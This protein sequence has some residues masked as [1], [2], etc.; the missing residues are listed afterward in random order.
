MHKKIKPEWCILI[1]SI[2]LFV[3]Y[4]GTVHLFDWDEINF[5]E[6]AR[7]MIVTGDYFRV[8]ID[9]RPFWEKPPLFIWMQVLSMKIFGINEFSA[10]FP[11]AIA[12]IATLQILYYL[13][14]KM[15]NHFFGLIW[16]MVYAGTFLT[17][18]YFKT[19]I[20]DP[21][22]NLFIFLSVY[23][24]SFLTN[25]VTQ[26]RIWR[27]VY[28]GLFLGLAVL[29]KGPV[30]ILIVLLSLILFLVLNRFRK[31]VSLKELLVL[32][33][34]SAV[35][36]FFWFGVELLK[37]GPWFLQEFIV[38]QI[39]L[40]QTQDAGHGG[41]FF[42]HW[43]VI[44][45][46]CFP[47]SLFFVKAYLLR[48]TIDNEHRNFYRWMN[49]LFWVVLIL[50]SIVKTK[51]IHYSS[52]CYFPLSFL[53]AYAI[54]FLLKEK[55]K[56]AKW[57]NYSVLIIGVLI[58]TLLIIFPML[59]MNKLSWIEFIKDDF[60]RANLDA[61]INWSIIDSLGG[62][63]LMLGLI[64]F[65][66]YNS[67]LENWKAIRSLFLSITM[68]MFFTSLLLV[69]KIEL[70]SQAAA[71][72]FYEGL[73]G[74]DVYVQPMYF[75]SFAHLFYFQ[76]PIPKVDSSYSHEWLREGNID[77]PVYAI[78]K[79]TKKEEMAKYTQFSLVKEENGFAFYLRLPQKK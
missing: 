24:F 3:P 72:R 42:Y 41:P 74:Q 22:F 57:I 4:L 66:W 58:S 13:G 79:N 26:N 62:F 54:Y 75:K 21:W 31:S 48:G 23:H 69:P 68:T 40:F 61:V 12:G 55:I 43:I 65:Y 17:F 63:I 44:L 53:A 64:G 36:C 11:N 47:A 59:M 14:K 20:I 45:F 8:R 51:I 70:F 19:G 10:R 67:K 52:L 76:K 25:S 34:S 18:I 29:T 7:E 38:Y 15:Y 71:I 77:K 46:G 49:I 78:V 6:A 56:I 37:N 16:V 27:S 32:A 73:K 35:I 9:F 2:I 60:A 5:A 30:A 33:F 1:L 39:R 28:S 50:F